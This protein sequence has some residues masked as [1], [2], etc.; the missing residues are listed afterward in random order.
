MNSFPNHWFGTW[1][2]KNGKKVLIERHLLGKITTSVIDQDNNPYEIVLLGGVKKKTLLLKSEYTKDSEQIPMLQIEAGNVDIG[3][4][5]RL[6]F[7]VEEKD[8]RRIA[9]EFDDS[10]LLKILPEVSIGLY[11]DYEE[12]LGVPWAFPLEEFTKAI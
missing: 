11:D 4:T 1:I 8:T 3:P 9:N 12:D 7:V 5:Y 2:D 10:R 6:Y